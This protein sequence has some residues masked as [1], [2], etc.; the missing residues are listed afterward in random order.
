M[1]KYYTMKKAFDLC[2]DDDAP[3]LDDADL[4]FNN[5]LKRSKKQI[6]E[7]HKIRGTETDPR[8]AFKL[9][10]VGLSDKWQIQKAEP[11]VYTSGEEYM[12]NNY[13]VGYWDDLFKPQRVIDAFLSGEKNGQLKEWLRPKQVELRRTVKNILRVLGEIVD[14]KN[15]F[16]NEYSMLD[17]ALEDLKPPT[18]D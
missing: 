6:L 3:F 2:G 1:K 18:G 5:V 15:R 13:G 8:T 12:C 4:G 9:L 7:D 10:K 14:P 16:Y 11:K 17:D